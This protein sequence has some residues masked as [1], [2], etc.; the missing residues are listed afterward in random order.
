MKKTFFSLLTGAVLAIGHMSHAQDDLTKMLDDAAPKGPDYVQGTFKATRIINLHSVEQLKAYHLDFRIHHRFGPLNS[1]MEQFWGLDAASIKLSLEY[2]I[3]DDLMVGIGRSSIQKMID[4]FVKY[5]ILK[6]ANG[7]SPVTVSVYANTGLNTLRYPFGGA[8]DSIDWTLARRSSYA[9]Q[10]LIA[11]K[12]NDRLSLQLSPT[13]VH[14]NVVA[15]TTDQNGVMA[16]GAGGRY[17]LS[18]RIALTGEYIYQLPGANRDQY[19]D[20]FSAGLDI[21]TG[22]HVFQLFFTNSPG[23]VEQHFVAMNAGGWGKGNISFG[24]NISRNFSLKRSAASTPSE[25]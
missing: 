22:G 2:G 1:G 11:R 19:W 13:Y 15:N 10:L 25:W 8:S 20:S 5:R 23:M 21:E 18:K 3:T 14:R 17:K 6:Q 7:G 16:I 9:T 24:F 12:F 4:G